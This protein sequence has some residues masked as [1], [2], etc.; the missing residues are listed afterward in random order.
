MNA[1]S[2]AVVRSQRLTPEPAEALANLLETSVPTGTLPP[3]W[4]SVYLLERPRQSDLGPDGH[5]VH[6]LPHPPGHGARR[7]F[8]G[9]R[10]RIHAP[11]E[12]GIDTTRTSEVLGT[13]HKRGRSGELTFVTVRHRYVQGDTLKVDVEDDIVYR[14]PVDPVAPGSGSAPASAEHSVPEGSEELLVKAIDATFLFRYSALT[15]NAHRI[16]YDRAWCER[17]GYA[18]LV[19]H[20]PLQALL[21][22]EALRLHGRSLVGAKFDYRLVAPLVGEQVVAVR[23]VSEHEVVVTAENGVTTARAAVGG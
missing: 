16:H 7:M 3:L 13:T 8:A 18:G 6:G 1:V 5:P 11:L 10:V 9:G 15:Y 4:H 12:L 22:A 23:R 19:I 14:P 21:M 2:D 17:E 20:G